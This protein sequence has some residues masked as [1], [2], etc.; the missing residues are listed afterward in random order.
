MA[1]CKACGAE[2][3]PTMKYCGACGCPVEEVS[4]RVTWADLARDGGARDVD[5]SAVAT[6]V[7]AQSGGLPVAAPNVSLQDSGPLPAAPTGQG[8]VA[9]QGSGASVQ[10]FAQSGSVQDF[11]QSGSARD[12][13]QS[14]NAQGHEFGAFGAGRAP[15]EQ[16]AMQGA[17]VP[18]YGAADPM[19][20]AQHAASRRAQRGGLPT[21]VL[22]VAACALVGTLVGVGLHGLVSPRDETIA[23]SSDG[24]AA[25]AAAPADEAVE[26][27]ADE[28][29]DEDVYI[30]EP[31]ESAETVDSST[32]EALEAV[33]D[34]DEGADPSAN[35]E[36]DEPE[37]ANADV[38]AYFPRSWSGTYEGYSQHVSGGVIT[39]SIDINFTSVGD[40]GALAGTC[41]IGVA[42][43]GDGAGGGSYNVEGTIDWATGAIRLWGTTWID[44][45]TLVGMRSFA[46]TFDSA[47]SLIWGTSSDGTHEG[48]WEMRPR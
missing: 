39:R 23:Y 28:D 46:G 35:E 48:S 47:N 38:S 8:Q 1:F 7:G 36:A 20:P 40:D 17:A 12:V 22:A 24:D 13:A 37:S 32:D 16:G 2:L 21:A 44:A 9:A 4:A 31:A 41:A 18:S 33:A 26:S 29:A 25:E 43:T 19:L 30:E 42:Q 15:Y 34:S 3:T 14:A 45:G 10:D 27:S 11:A 5:A 6:N